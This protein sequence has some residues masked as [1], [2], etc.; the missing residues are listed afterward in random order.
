MHWTEVYLKVR[1]YFC[2]NC[3]KKCT[4]LNRQLCA[5]QNLWIV[6]HW[7]IE[8]EFEEKMRGLQ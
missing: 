7:E 1:D 5:E 8:Q 4:E 3:H 2:N 6:Q